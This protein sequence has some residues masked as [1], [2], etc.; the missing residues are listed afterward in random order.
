M[1]IET[2]GMASIVQAGTARE[3]VRVLVVDTSLAE[4]R[5]MTSLPFGKSFLV[6]FLLGDM[7]WQQAD[8]RAAVGHLLQN[9]ANSFYFHGNHCKEAE[10]IADSVIVEQFGDRETSESVIL[11][12]SSTKS[13]NEF[14]EDLYLMFPASGYMDVW[15]SDVF[16]CIAGSEQARHVTSLLS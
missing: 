4:I 8:L 10:S 7:R 12:V 11:T 6:A 15:E 2:V 3:G 5:P 16:L 1:A 13:L 14:L 9:G